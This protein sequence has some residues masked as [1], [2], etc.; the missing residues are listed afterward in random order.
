MGRKQSSQWM[1]ESGETVGEIAQSRSDAATL[2]QT[3]EKLCMT[4]LLEDG[5][6]V[7]IGRCSSIV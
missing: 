1:T 7:K 2:K 3:N 6:V 4:S 5:W